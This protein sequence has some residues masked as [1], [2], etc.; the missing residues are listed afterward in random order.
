MR[1]ML[2]LISLGTAMIV[3]GM[4]AAT[5]IAG[6]STLPAPIGTVDVSGPCDEAEHANDPECGGVLVPEDEATSAPEVEE[7]DEPGDIS[8]P[9]DEAE[10]ANDPRCTGASSDDDRSGPSDDG[11]ED[12]SGPSENSG[13]GNADDDDHDADDDADDHGDDDDHDA[14]DG[15]DD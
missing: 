3:T 4:L 10:H 7:T 11:D 9:C 13:P 12:N 8:G 2:M 1:R 15:D 5:A 14:D 6:D